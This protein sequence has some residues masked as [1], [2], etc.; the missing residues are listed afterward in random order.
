MKKFLSLLMVVALSFSLVACAEELPESEKDFYG[1]F[2]NNIDDLNY[3]RSNMQTNNRHFANFVDGLVENDQYGKIVPSLAESWSSE[4]IDNGE[5]QEWTFNIR[6]G[7]KW[8]TNDGEHYADV[9]AHDWV[10]PAQWLLDPANASSTTQLWFAF[11]EGAEEYYC[12]KT[13]ETDPTSGCAEG[14]D[15][16]TTD[17]SDVG[18]K[19][20]DDQTLVYTLKQPAPYFPTVLTYSPFFPVNE[21]FLL[22]QGPLFGTDEATILYSGAYIL[23]NQE[24]DAKIEYA[25]N[26]DYWDAKHV[27]IENVTLAFIPDGIG[28]DFFRLRFENGELTSFRLQES[29]TIGWQNYI[30]GD[31]DT[32]SLQD[33]AHPNA[34]TTSS[35]GTTTYYFT[36]NFNRDVNSESYNE[37]TVDQLTDSNVAINDAN[38]R[39]GFLYGMNRPTYL[40]RY[41]A[42]NPEQWIR[43]TYIPRELTTDE[44]G[45][46]YVD[47]FVAEYAEKEDM[48][49]EDATAFLADGKDTLYDVAKATEYFA[50][51]KAAN[52]N[53]SWPINIEIMVSNDT[54]GN[55]Y[56]YTKAMA[57]KMTEEF[58]E[59]VNVQLQIPANRDMYELWADEHNYHMDWIGWGP[60]YADPA[61]F[62]NSVKSDGSMAQYSGLSGKDGEAFLA[63]FEA[64]VDAAQEIY[65]PNNLS[66]RFAK[67]AEA[68]YKFV[69]E[70][71]VIIPFLG[72]GGGNAYVSKIKPFTAMY[73]PYGLSEDKFKHMV[74]LPEPITAEE[75]NALKADWEAERKAN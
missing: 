66:E 34:Y 44:N 70:D 72:V 54:A 36:F 73:A 58:G 45:T 43:N 47:H 22:E 28:N 49:I 12:G 48:S 23:T 53:L 29:D 35:Y 30:L 62:F 55:H 19:A 27:Y 69:Y 6:T 40:A 25:K 68:E 75:R 61:T 32:G 63:D 26:V 37:L 14:L 9:T 50:A 65:D 38:F 24:L 57:D 46:D 39:K 56:I 42:G 64:M 15:Y 67:F 13:L 71:V 17:F 1:T 11:I 74:I 21:D 59:Y 60:D 2:S 4:V 8:V 31:E 20:T 3:M 10:T 5:K 51:A 52:P 18:V 41:T 16:T 7:A 33:P